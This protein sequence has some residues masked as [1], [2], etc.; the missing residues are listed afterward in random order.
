MVGYYGDVFIQSSG[1][2]YGGSKWSAAMIEG[3]G[4]VRS[5]DRDTLHELSHDLTSYVD[6]NNER[7]YRLIKD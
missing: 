7:V 4:S 3:S 5:N 2:R 1:F 6:N